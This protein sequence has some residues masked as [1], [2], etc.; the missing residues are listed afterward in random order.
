MYKPILFLICLL[1]AAACAT[2]TSVTTPSPALP[3]AISDQEIAAAVKQAHDTLNIVREA[4]LSS[5][6]SRRFIGLKVRFAGEDGEFEDHWTEPVD[7]YNDVFTIR[8]LDGLTLD[9]GLH[10]NQFVDVNVKEVLDWMIVESDGRL[11]GGYTLRLAYD[12]MTPDEQ[13]EFLK[14]T[15]YVME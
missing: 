5:K 12:H 6:Q 2:L 3:S 1:L 4:L 8:M 13:K 9:I 7:Y 15:G 10:P 14:V 11:I